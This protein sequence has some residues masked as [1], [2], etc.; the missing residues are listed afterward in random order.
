MPWDSTFGD[1]LSPIDKLKQTG[2]LETARELLR[3]IAPP[4]MVQKARSLVEMRNPDGGLGYVER[5][6]L[7][8]LLAWRRDGSGVNASAW[9]LVSTARLRETVGQAGQDGNRRLRSALT[10]LSEVVV[11]LETESCGT[12]DT[13]LLADFDLPAGAG[14]LAYRISDVVL[15][16]VALPHAYATLDLR[17]CSALGSKHALVLYELAALLANRKF[18]K[19]TLS[20]ADVRAHFGLARRYSGAAALRKHVI[21]PAI[22]TVSAGTALRVTA[23]WQKGH[24]KRATGVMLEVAKAE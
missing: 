1:D 10:R 19:A 13:V 18:P 14:I 16:D 5:K 9:T 22:D 20:L 3:D 24:R 8:A 7:N 4:L 12:A 2:R 21:A 17:V 6:L 15:P 23:T 11:R